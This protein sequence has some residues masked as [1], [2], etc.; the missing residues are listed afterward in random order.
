VL[1]RQRSRA[2][3]ADMTFTER[4]SFFAADLPGGRDAAGQKF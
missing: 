4:R 2:Q 1:R 3:H